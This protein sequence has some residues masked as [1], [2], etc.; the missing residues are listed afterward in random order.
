MLNVLKNYLYENSDDEKEGYYYQALMGVYILK[1]NEVEMPRVTAGQVWSAYIDNTPKTLKLG[2]HKLVAMW[3]KGVKRLDCQVAHRNITAFA[4]KYGESY[5]TEIMLN[6][7]YILAG[8][9]TSLKSGVYDVFC[10]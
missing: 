2:M 9:D 3:V 5:F 7:E 10:E 4:S 8:D 6:F 1:D